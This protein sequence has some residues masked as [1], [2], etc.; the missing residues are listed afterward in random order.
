MN[1]L[2]AHDINALIPILT[3]AERKEMNQLSNELFGG[4]PMVFPTPDLPKDKVD[5]YKFLAK[6]KM[7]C[8]QALMN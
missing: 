1:F 7:E 4:M 6:K 8:I 5:R 3:Q 2:K